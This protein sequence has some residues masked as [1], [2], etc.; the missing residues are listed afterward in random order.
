MVMAFA[1]LNST[2]QER[3]VRRKKFWVVGKLL[4]K[5]K[6]ESLCPEWDVQYKGRNGELE[7]MSNSDVTISKHFYSPTS[8]Q[9]E[10]YLP[11]SP[12]EQ[13]IFPG[14]ISR[15]TMPFFRKY[16]SPPAKHRKHNRDQC[17]QHL[18]YINKRPYNDYMNFIE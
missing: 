6:C 1:D 9:C 4:N 14:L 3:F 7:L 8:Q 5:V 13:R 16:S 18:A 12:T 11:S 15:C 10:L 2:I 17:I